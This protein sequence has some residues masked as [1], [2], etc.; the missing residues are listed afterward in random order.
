MSDVQQRRR[1][2]ILVMNIM[3]LESEGLPP[4][5]EGSMSMPRIST[6]ARLCF[7][8][9]PQH[10]SKTRRNIIRTKTWKAAAERSSLA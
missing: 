8:M 3:I 9:F 5:L 7:A 1:A 4:G 2:G 10:A 6:I